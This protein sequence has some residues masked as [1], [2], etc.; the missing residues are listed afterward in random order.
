MDL[1]TRFDQNEIFVIVAFIISYI[2]VLLLPKRFPLAITILIMVFAS[3]VA[4]LSDHL[5]SGTLI[6]LYDVMDTG[7]YELFDLFVYLLYPPFCYLFIYV[8]DK[9]K[10]TGLSIVLFIIACSIIGMLFEGLCVLF[11]VFQYK[12]W[13]L[14]YSFSFYLFIQSSTLV[15][16][17]YICKIVNLERKKHVPK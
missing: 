16:F 13:K 7:K 11:D 17:V 14:Y 9:C 4:R 15:F 2:I 10:P 5:I 3:I 8:Y 1:P 12:G 6:D